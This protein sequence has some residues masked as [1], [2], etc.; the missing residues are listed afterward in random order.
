[1]KGYNETNL[2]SIA[3]MRKAKEIAASRNTEILKCTLALRFVDRFMTR[4]NS[5][6][7]TL[8]IA[9]NQQLDRAINELKRLGL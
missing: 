1:M 7:T 3:V 5:D 2:R 8:V 4:W 9:G 6:A